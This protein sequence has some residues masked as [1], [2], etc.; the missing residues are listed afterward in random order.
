MR[1]MA[2]FLALA[3]SPTFAQSS[4]TLDDFEGGAIAGWPAAASLTT[5]AA[6]GRHACRG[7]RR[8]APTPRS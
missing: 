7:R 8:R 4:L 5:D 1:L 2:A 6:Q 3:L